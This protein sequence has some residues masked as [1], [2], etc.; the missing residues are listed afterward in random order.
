MTDYPSVDM[1]QT[2]QNRSD[3]RPVRWAPRQAGWVKVKTDAGFNRDKGIGSTG[4]L[5][6]NHDGDVLIT[7]WKTVAEA[8]ACLQGLRLALEWSQQPVIVE[9][10]CLSMIRAV[11]TTEEDRASWAGLIQEIKGVS[12]L[13]PDCRFIRVRREGNLVAHRLAR[14]AL[15]FNECGLGRFSSPECARNQC[16]IEAAGARGAVVCNTVVNHQ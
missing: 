12:V 10:D 7:A 1:R 3:Q 2:P 6:R 14:R 16:I 5:I 15:Q 4:I 11:L 9:A 13:L 8:E